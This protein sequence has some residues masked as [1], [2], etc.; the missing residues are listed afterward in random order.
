MPRHDDDIAQKFYS[1]YRVAKTR[2]FV[3]KIKENDD[4]SVLEEKQ[5]QAIKDP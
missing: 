3:L 4:R 2:Q 1:S 5:D